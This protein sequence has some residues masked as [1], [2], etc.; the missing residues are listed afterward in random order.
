MHV[1]GS[2]IY[3]P[4]FEVLLECGF[5][6]SNN[7]LRDYKDNK[8]KFNTNTLIKHL[9]EEQYGDSPALLAKYQQLDK[10]EK[11]LF[12]DGL[13]NIQSTRSKSALIQKIEENF[14]YIIISTNT[15]VQYILHEHVKYIHEGQQNHAKNYIFHTDGRRCHSNGF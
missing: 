14:Q 3:L 8:A 9:F 11:I 12:I 13:D 10:S 2:C 5:S 7:L 1:T 4:D 6:Q 15:V